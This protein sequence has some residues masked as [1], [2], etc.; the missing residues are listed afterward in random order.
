ME[1]GELVRG[2]ARGMEKC[3]KYA[4]STE[5]HSTNAFE[6][7]IPKCSALNAS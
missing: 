6:S 3:G 1:N 4:G 7:T 5:L 2:A